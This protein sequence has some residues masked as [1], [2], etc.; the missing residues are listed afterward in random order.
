MTKCSIVSVRFNE[1]SFT[2]TICTV[3]VQGYVAALCESTFLHSMSYS[4]LQLC[5][6]LALST[7]LFNFAI[8][9]KSF[10][11]VHGRLTSCIHPRFYCKLLLLLLL[12]LLSG[13][14]ITKI[15]WTTHVKTQDCKI[16]DT[17]KCECKR[18]R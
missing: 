9:I 13:V 5:L 17:I 12:L 11:C 10:T 4:L 15:I 18:S 8:L 2:S 3:L 6:L 7:L 14:H 1:F 16:I